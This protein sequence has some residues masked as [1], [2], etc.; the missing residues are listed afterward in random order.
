MKRLFFICLVLTITTPCL[1]ATVGGPDISIPEGSMCLKDK[2]VKQ[3]L[4]RYD[5]NMNIKAGLDTE[6]ITSRKLNTSS[7]VTNAKIEGQN[8]VFKLSTNF[9]DLFEPYIKVG[10]CN[11]KLK[12]NQSGNGVTVETEPGLVWGGGAKIKVWESDR[13]KIKLTLDAQYRKIDAGVDRISVS[14]AQDDNFEIGEMQISLLA[15]KKYVFPL[16]LRDYYIVPYGGLTYYRTDVD[17]SFTQSTTGSLY[18]TYNA[19]DKR[20]IGIVMGLDIMPSLLSW[21]LFNFEMRL[22]NETAFTLG[23]TLKF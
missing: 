13:Y 15:S 9:G 2:T 21:Y 7:E 4:D 22:V 1:A 11:L 14:S 10:T 3:T 6:F 8:V 17:V 5:Y 20:E 16:G 12:W 23:G 19:S 18:S